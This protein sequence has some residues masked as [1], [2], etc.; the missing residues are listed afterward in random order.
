MLLEVGTQGRSNGFQAP[1][2]RFLRMLLVFV[3]RL[4][5][6]IVFLVPIGYCVLPILSERIDHPLLVARN[7]RIR[8]EQRQTM[9]VLADRIS[10]R[11]CL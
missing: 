4:A 1:G 10:L 2:V 6:R 5:R 9:I 3:R 7:R 8:A 11:S